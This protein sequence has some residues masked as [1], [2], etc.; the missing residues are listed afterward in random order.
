MKGD[1]INVLVRDQVTSISASVSGRTVEAS[2][3]KENGITWLVVKEATRGGTII[4]E[5]RFQ[6]TD[7]VMWEKVSG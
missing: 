3:E 5:A 6:I 1:H 4:H 2:T 7:V